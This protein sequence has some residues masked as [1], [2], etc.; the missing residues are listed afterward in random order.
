ML[1][2]MGSAGVVQIASAG[3]SEMYYYFVLCC[4]VLCM[5]ACGEAGAYLVL[6]FEG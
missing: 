2:A 1:Q 4:V 6:A 5:H 3:L